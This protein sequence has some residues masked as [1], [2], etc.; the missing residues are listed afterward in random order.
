MFGWKHSVNLK[1]LLAESINF[2]ELYRFILN[3]RAKLKGVL[4]TS[5]FIMH[6]KNVSVNMQKRH[7]SNLKCLL[8]KKLLLKFQI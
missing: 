5:V 4:V 6:F 2:K 1:T 3:K 8:V 7:L